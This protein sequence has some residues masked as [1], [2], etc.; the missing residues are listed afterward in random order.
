M[1]ITVKKYTG[2][3]AD[4]QDL[5]LEGVPLAKLEFLAKWDVY[6]GYEDGV[7]KG[8]FLFTPASAPHIASET[9]PLLA[10]PSCAHLYCPDAQGVLTALLKQIRATCA[11]QGH[12]SFFAVNL[13]GIE[14]ATWMRLFRAAGEAK[15]V[16][17]VFEFVVT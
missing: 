9:H 1:T 16:G 14:D 13:T 3:A 15:A 12:R 10:L 4:F 8:Y 6:V 17:S 2:D 5:T 11:E 7:A